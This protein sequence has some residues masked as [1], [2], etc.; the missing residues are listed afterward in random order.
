[1][2][3]SEALNIIMKVMDELSYEQHE[4]EADT[5]LTQLEFHGIIRPIKVIENSETLVINQ[6]GQVIS[7]TEDSEVIEIGWEDEEK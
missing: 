1:M 2:K 4:W 5:I 6:F 3:R 7:K